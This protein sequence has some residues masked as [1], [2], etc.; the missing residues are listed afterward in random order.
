MWRKGTPRLLAS[1]DDAHLHE[2]SG[3]KWLALNPLV[4]KALGW[5]PV[6]GNWFCWANQSGDLVARSLWWKDGLIEQY[7]VYLHVEVGE[8]WLVLVS[9]PG[10]EEIKQWKKSLTRGGVVRRSLGEY[11]MRGHGHARCILELV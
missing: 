8:G 9:R 6:S 1:R 11:S 5:H 2:T 3:S 4:G 10:F 7:S